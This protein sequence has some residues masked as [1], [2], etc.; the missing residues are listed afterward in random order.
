MNTSPKLPA[1]TDVMGAPAANAVTAVAGARRS[2][3]DPDMFHVME[4]RDNA[5]IADEIMHGV[6]SKKFVYDFSV[7]GTK[8]SGVS[9]VGAAYLAAHYGGLKHRII[10]SADKNGSLFK[11]QS[12]Q[13][14]DVRAQRLPELAEDSD[15]YEVIVE[16]EDIK[17]GNTVQVRKRESKTEFK[18][19][20]SAYDR[21][22]YS[23]IAESKAYRNAVL[24]LVPANIVE[25]FKRKC[26]AQGDS[27]DMTGGLMNEKRGGVLR[28]AT[29]QG[30]TVDREALEQM[31]FD[32]I[33]GLRD[34]AEDGLPAFVAAMTGAG[35]TFADDAGEA[36]Q[37]E[38]QPSKPGRT[39]AS[40]AKPAKP[41]EKAKAKA[42]DQADPGAQLDDDI[43]SAETKTVETTTET[44]D[45][46][47]GEVTEAEGDEDVTEAAEADDDGDELFGDA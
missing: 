35:L 4:R 44:V 28:F 47:T 7:S 34:A 38:K 42:K 6:S 8:V 27:E 43:A 5:L 19:D 46:D 17:T 23:V 13:P 25:E 2:A 11:L 37:V 21:P 9:V 16:V 32:Q 39:P 40:G 10:A 1:S 3:F 15:Y 14:L 12:Y 20:G 36:K 33:S 41:K 18:R 22:H 30:L 31:T 24:R 45:P 26:L 29:A